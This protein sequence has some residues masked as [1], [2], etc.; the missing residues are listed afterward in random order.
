MPIQRYIAA[1]RETIGA[2]PRREYITVVFVMSKFPAVYIPPYRSKSAS[3]KRC[4]IR[5]VV[6]IITIVIMIIFACERR[7][8]RGLNK[9]CFSR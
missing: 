8:V 1:Q 5:I 6:S 2:R 7:V 3:Q 4:T 9:L